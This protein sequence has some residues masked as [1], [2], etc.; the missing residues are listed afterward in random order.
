MPIN[1]IQF[2]AEIGNFNGIFQHINFF[3]KINWYNYVFVEM[4]SF[5]F[6]ISKLKFCNLIL[7]YLAC[8][9]FILIV[10]PMILIF[11]LSF[12][13]ITRFV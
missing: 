9:L 6:M 3:T 4:T 1:N 2:R 8:L 10:F 11:T 13:N 5:L 7:L 12:G